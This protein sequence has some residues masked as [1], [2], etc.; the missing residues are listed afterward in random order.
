MKKLI[1]LFLAATMLL[2]LLVPVA[3]GAEA[4]P[5]A[6]TVILE[7]DFEA[8]EVGK[9]PP[10]TAAGWTTG[11]IKDVPRAYVEYDT[12]GKNKVLKAY[13]GNPEGEPGTRT[14]RI[15]K[16]ISTAG[17]TNFTLEYDVKCSM[18]ESTMNMSLMEADA[19]NTSISNIKP[20]YKYAD[21]TPMRIEF[22]VKDGV[23][24]VYADGKR[25]KIV[26]F[27][28]SGRDQFKLR[29]S[30]SVSSNDGSWVMIDNV[31]IT[32]TD[33][34]LGGIIGL[35]GETINW[36]KVKLAESDKT[37]ML[38]VMRKS[39]PRLYTTDWDAINKKAET[40]ESCYSW[41]EAVIKAGDSRLNAP[42]Q[43]YFRNDRDNLNDCSSAFRGA[44]IPLAAAYCLTKDVRYKDRLY[45]EL[46]HVGN[47][48][49]WGADAY[50]CT[51]HNILTFAVCYD[52]LYNDWTKEERENILG[53]LMEKGIR[54]AVLGYE[55]Y[56]KGTNWVVSKSNW[57]NVC[58]GSNLIAALAI[59]DEYPD[60]ADYL[61]RKAATSLPKCF[62]E[63]SADGAY[64]EPLNYWDYGIRYQVKAMAALDSCLIE[65]ASLPECL[66]FKDITGM[67]N[68]G[69]FAIYYN[70]ITAAFNYGDA[71]PGMIVSPI[72]FYF[73]NKYDKPQYAWYNQYMYENSPYVS[74]ETGKEAVWSLLWYDPDNAQM[75]EGGFA[76]D[77][78]YQ[79]METLGLNGISMRSSW[80]DQ[81]ALFIA[82]RAGDQQASHSSLD[83]GGFVL[84]WAGKRWVHMYGRRVAGEASVYGWPNYHTKN[85]NG[86]YSYYHCRAEA[87]NTIIANPVQNDAD[88][89]VKYFAEL[90]E[91]KSGTNTAYGIINMTDTN[92]DYEDAKRGLMLTD[93]RSVIVI[94]DEIKAKKPSE[95]YWF[96]NTKADVTIA[97][98]G[99]SALLEMG[100]DRML[101]RIT[102]GPADAKI[103]V[104][105]SQP[106]PTSPNPSIQP[107]LEEHKLFI[108]MENVSTLN[109][110]VEFVPLADGE[111]IPAPQ[112]VVPLA[113]WSV[114]EGAPQLTSQKLG[115][116]VALKVD[117]PNAYAKGAKTYVDTENL[118][119]MPIVQEGRTLVPVRFIAENFGA[120]VGWDDATQTVTLKTLAK[121][122]TLQIGNNTM[123][124]GDN[125]VTLDVPA[126]TIG[127]RTLIPLRALVEALGKEV[128]W[129]DRGLILIGNDVLGTA[130]DTIDKTVALLDTRIQYGGKELT[131]FDSEIY[132]YD[133]QIAKG[134]A[135]PEVTVQSSEE[136]S[137]V[138]GNPATVTVGDKTYT[139]RFVENPFEGLLGT[140]SA[141]VLNQLKLQVAGAT[142]DFGYQTYLDVQEVTSSIV[143]DVKYQPSGTI[144]GVISEDTIN[145]W[146]A[147]GEGNWIA[148]D[149]G[150]A[151]TLHSIAIAGYKSSQRSYTFEIATSNDGQNWATAVAQAITE[152]GVDRTV[153]K[154]GDVNARYIKITGIA[155]TGTT[156]MGI[157]EVRI[158]SSAQMEADD[159]SVWAL[160]FSKEGIY[161]TVGNSVQLTISG[162]EKGGAAV[163]VSITDVSLS[164]MDPSIATVDANGHV[165][166][167]KSGST[168]IVAEM[169]VIGIQKKATL[170]VT[171]E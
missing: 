10:Y 93:N 86:H 90:L 164:S 81:D 156:W 140:A 100:G 31:K 64:A 18:G 112:P 47:W 157:N 9:A 171:V 37:G 14:P 73:A 49:D 124:V 142:T 77:K 1:S 97:E 19:S 168:T 106:L 159:Q 85:A 129:D 46:E 123:M 15:E 55:G 30:F 126:Q 137:V 98:D 133:V 148:Y 3:Y 132:E 44:T 160:N 136:A 103:G 94:Q 138:Q 88:M 22:D 4:E 125:A 87:N 56:T 17:L 52:W 82:M 80:T 74:A 122:I 104:M 33:T 91:G 105:M 23:A 21:W 162:M 166:L 7:D 6:L 95:F 61:L 167:L 35:D 54:E 12:D 139:I 121:T 76:L 65:G 114:D 78:Y 2:A 39:H 143:W 67:S 130:A 45:K 48:P 155:A 161:G 165:K 141:G 89:N 111:A 150:S 154:L 113:N 119:I 28:L 149:L 40:D 32:S 20:S 27:D 66:D 11:A 170:K 84:D 115:D 117:N 147:D 109:L 116:V 72:M 169:T 134:E 26:S 25:E 38:E 50:L 92:A 68:T 153:F 99:K 135:I 24:T 75:P 108:H 41:R 128:L 163:P 151:Q 58:N 63:L 34:G 13:H 127:G 70:G 53:W 96:S 69:D 110:T 107:M 60:V 16:Q 59:A 42:P 36:D 29:I 131:F 101:V 158:Y 145:R 51:A 120:T 62:H 83:A 118:D 43:D 144:D 146:S 102:Q 5:E 152:P 79:S 8:H 57:N 71:D